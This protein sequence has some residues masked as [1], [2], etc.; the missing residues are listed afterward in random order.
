MCDIKKYQS[1]KKE[2]CEITEM[3]Q[4]TEVSSIGSN[5]KNTTATGQQTMANTKIGQTARLV[6]LRAAVEKRVIVGL[7]AAI[8]MLS[9]TPDESLF[10]FLAQSEDSATHMNKT[11][12]E[13]FCNEHYIYI[14]KVDNAEKL[15]RILGA[16]PF[17]KRASC[18]LIQ[19]SWLPADDLQMD[20]DLMLTP[21]E[22]ILVDHCEQY[23][24]FPNQVMQLPV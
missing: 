7:S 15:S 21:T 10:C 12:L 9:Q 19:K 5:S 11:L 20:G 23:W 18:A 16:S 1:T 6:L 22:Q 3:V 24:D 14:V 4:L 17:D 8:S 2:G 13:A